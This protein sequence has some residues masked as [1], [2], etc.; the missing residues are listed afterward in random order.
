MVEQLDGAS[1]AEPDGDGNRLL[2]TRRRFIRKS[3][4]LLG[5][6]LAPGR[7]ETIAA[8]LAPVLPLAP[9]AFVALPLGSIR[10]Q[11]WV[12]HQLELQRDGITGHAEELFP[13][14]APNSGWKG[15]NGEGWQSGPYYLKG[16]IPLAYT[17]DDT[18]LKAKVAAWIKPILASQQADGFFGPTKNDDWWPRMLV[19]YILRDYAEATGDARVVPFLTRYYRYQLEKLPTRPLQDWGR[20]RVGDEIDTVLWLYNRTKDAFLLSL[21][22]LLADQGYPW[23]RIFNENRFFDYSDDGYPQHNVNVTQA[24]KMPPVYWQRSQKI[25]DKDAYRAAITHLMHD[26]GTSFGIN[27]GTE[28]LAGRSTVSGVET[29]AIVEYMLSAETALRILGDAR[30]G[31]ELEVVAFNALPASLSKD[32]HQ[33]VYYTMANNVVAKRGKV[34]YPEDHGDDRNPAP[35]SGY[36]CC[37]YNLHMG[38]P[39]LVQNAWAATGEGNGLATL[40]Y[41]PSQVTTTVAQGQAVTVT[42]DTH[43]PFAGTIRLT[44]SLKKEARFPLRLRIPGWCKAPQIHL[45]DTPQ[46]A[47]TG[48]TFATID[49]V[50][51]EGDLVE[52]RFPMEVE[53]V[54][55]VNQ[56]ISVRR[57]PLV[58]ALGLNET[59]TPFEQHHV[60]GFAS[61]D[62]TSDSPWNFGLVLDAQHPARSFEIVPKAFPKNP[63]ETGKAPIALRVSGKRLAQWTLRFDGHVPHD[64]PVSPVASDAP[65]ESLELVPFGSQMLRIS[66]FP[67]IGKPLPASPSAWKEDFRGDY[68][69]RW[70]VQRGSIVRDGRM[71]LP[72][73]A[74]GVAFRALFSDVSYQGEVIVGTKGNAG[75]IFRATDLSIGPDHYRGYYVGISAE[76]QQLILGKS[77]NA[78]EEIKTLRH[79]ITAGRTY[80]LRVEARGDRIQV[81]I[82]DAK[83]PVVDARD[84]SFSSGALGVRSYSNTA[85]FGKLS[86]TSV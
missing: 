2:T 73:I 46:P 31:D 13:D 43:Y 52:L 44:V 42:C 23:S 11:G 71:H 18:A 70:L 53:T 32:I 63:F 25:E 34:G 7:E 16:L 10:A 30:I 76:N 38:W 61:Y 67:V 5:G 78:W 65:T 69:E 62:V 60:P 15:G 64:P 74:K 3:A 59:W 51:K 80:T 40:V 68:A 36:P 48:G 33:N 12:L 14:T 75:L 85:S 84:S 55:E 49:R 41:V 45:N 58:Y 20:A 79:P 28:S 1:L 29:C 21:A 86:A 66:A 27:T 50:W 72:F 4:V 17:L 35:R 56:A 19:T 77:N 47:P 37:C 9:A 57:G 81:W 54:P 22:D 8:P 6:L 83:T 39:K 82:D 24:L 26:H